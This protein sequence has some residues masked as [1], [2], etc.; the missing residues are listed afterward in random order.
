MAMVDASLSAPIPASSTSLAFFSSTNS[1]MLVWYTLNRMFPHQW[2]LTSEQSDARLIWVPHTRGLMWSTLRSEQWVNH[3]PESDSIFGND[4]ISEILSACSTSPYWWPPTF[5]VRSREDATQVMKMSDALSNVR[6]SDGKSLGVSYWLISPTRLPQQAPHLLRSIGDLNRVNWRKS[7]HGHILQKYIEDPLLIDGKRFEMRMFVLICGDRRV[8]CH[9]FP[10]LRLCTSKFALDATQL[11]AFVTSHFYN[12]F[13]PSDERCLDWEEWTLPTKSAL[14]EQAMLITEQVLTACSE[15]LLRATSIRKTSFEVL[16]LDFVVDTNERL[17]L[18][19]VE[20]NPNLQIGTESVQRRIPLLYADI[21]LATAGAQKGLSTDKVPLQSLL[22][23]API[24]K[25]GSR[26]A[27]ALPL[28][29]GFSSCW[30]CYLDVSAF[31]AKRILCQYGKLGKYKE[32]MSP[33]HH[34]LENWNRARY[35]DAVGEKDFSYYGRKAALIASEH[36]AHLQKHNGHWQLISVLVEMKQQGRLIEQVIE[37]SEKNAAMAKRKATGFFELTLEDLQTLTDIPNGAS[38]M[39]YTPRLLGHAGFPFKRYF[40]HHPQHYFQYLCLS[41]KPVLSSDVRTPSNCHI[42]HQELL[43]LNFR[44]DYLCLM[45]QP[46]DYDNIDILG[47]Y[48][49]EAARLAACRKDQLQSTLSKWQSDECFRL[50]STHDVLQIDRKVSALSLREAIYKSSRECTQFKPTLAYFVY[51][52]FRCRRTLDISAGWGD[53]LIG[54]MAADLEKY[55]ATDPNLSLKQGHEGMKKTLL[56]ADFESKAHKFSI[57]YEPFEDATFPEDMSVDLIFTSPPFFDFEIYT[58]SET[59]STSRY[60]NQ[61]DW[62]Q[63]FLF[64]V[65]EKAW[66]LLEVE[67]HLVVHIADTGKDK[68]CEPMCLHILANCPGSSFEGVLNSMGQAGRPRPLWVFVKKSVSDESVAM[69]EAAAAA[70]SD[71]M[72]ER[73][74]RGI[75]RKDMEAAEVV[76][77]GDKETMPGDS[78]AALEC[79]IWG[80]KLEEAALSLREMA[81]EKELNLNQLVSVRPFV[82]ED[83]AFLKYLTSQ[84]DVMQHI[85][86]GKPW[87]EKEVHQFL[88]YALKDERSP[89]IE[90]GDFQWA[91]TVKDQ[92]IGVVGLHFFRQFPIIDKRKSFFCTL[93]L[94]PHFQRLGIGQ[95]G[96]ASAVDKFRSLRPDITA[97]YAC[98][99][100]KNDASKRLF[101]GK[102]RFTPVTTV[103]LRNIPNLLLER[104]LV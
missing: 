25:Y 91:I 78:D 45:E 3:L 2:A 65:L 29:H 63:S 93:F 57:I 68:V 100:E 55:T 80:G 53:R 15:K 88:Q 27:Q 73:M 58:Q 96:M 86:H 40:M 67:G 62:L 98:I 85:K 28:R 37:R 35:V 34:F 44:G 54:A 74:G 59:Q 102:L 84:T 56:G 10:H 66:K 49:Q 81:R 21:L 20:R 71:L 32:Q 7:F 4:A 99:A 38:A 104:S 75:K 52:Y 8:F 1:D 77:E 47:D 43:P 46:A 24:G 90:R 95:H 103:P 50:R 87:S 36:S 89:P 22:P 31:L 5:I 60:P 33:F 64:P 92:P 72:G 41:Y 70:L 26:Q 9:K 61:S 11:S 48:F 83:M 23:L 79:T 14:L 69:K 94:D 19:R 97:I 30:A 101:M 17:W 42:L 82:R 13:A 39:L 6:G 12:L 51:K 76:R 16:A 18:Q